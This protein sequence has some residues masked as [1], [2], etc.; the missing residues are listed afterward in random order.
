MVRGVLSSVV[1]MRLVIFRW[2]RNKL[3][4]IHWLVSYLFSI[5]FFWWHS[6]STIYRS[7]L[8]INGLFGHFVF[9]TCKLVCW[10]FL[11]LIFFHNNLLMHLQW[12]VN[13][14]VIN[15]QELLIRLNSHHFLF[16]VSLGLRESLAQV[17]LLYVPAISS[18]C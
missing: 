8:R 7:C 2:G 18:F 6:P 9:L 3:C 11:T 10:H 5:I 17:P 15:S 12:M 13:D 16:L 14:V 4:K 1:F